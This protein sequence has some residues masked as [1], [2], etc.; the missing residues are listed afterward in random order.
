MFDTLSKARRSAVMARVRSCGNKDTEIALVKL[1]RR[2]HITGWQRNQSVFGKPDFV[3]RKFKLAVFVDGCFWHGCPKC[4]R[5]PASNRKYWDG[6]IVQNKSRDKLVNHQLQKLGWRVLRIWGHELA[7]KN[8][9]H[10]SSWIQR[11]LK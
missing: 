10:L 11:A 4:Y 9:A 8:E 2:N 7:K 5:R 3:F 6:K 1:L